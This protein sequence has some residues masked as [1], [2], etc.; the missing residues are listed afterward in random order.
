MLNPEKQVNNNRPNSLFVI[1]AKRYA[2]AGKLTEAAEICR[3]GL[4]YFPANLNG[5]VTLSQI[6]IAMNSRDRALNVLTDGYKRTGSRELFL[7]FKQIERNGKPNVVL[8][9][10]SNKSSAKLGDKETTSNSPESPQAENIAASKIDRTNLENYSQKS[11]DIKNEKI[12]PTSHVDEFV[13]DKFVEVEIIRST[14]QETDLQAKW[15][16]LKGNAAKEDL[17]SS[18]QY[19]L[20]DEVLAEGAKHELETDSIT[21]SINDSKLLEEYN[22]LN[23][24]AKQNKENRNSESNNLKLHVTESGSRLRSSNIRLIPGLEFAPL[25]Y[26]NKNEQFS[27]KDEGEVRNRKTISNLIS[28]EPTEDEN[29]I[30]DVETDST[31]EDMIVAQGVILKESYY[32]SLLNI[33][34]EEADEEYE[35]MLNSNEAERKLSPLEELA[36]RL[37]NARIPME[38]EDDTVLSPAFEPIIITETWADILANQGAYTEALKAYQTLA[39]SKPEL[40]EHF[41]NKIEDMKSKII[42]TQVQNSIVE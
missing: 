18:A 26:A 37:E 27:N 12:T 31:Q 15:N 24:I 2:N 35:K 10:N 9:N 1:E 28:N 42:E 3:R 8:I 13:V 36:K 5:Y 29:N 7:L 30:F 14:K 20:Q 4:I 21:D 41:K 33:T 22:L 6:Y 32:E 39:R 23:V 17:D 11:E 25:R 38:T 16:M 40:F 34:K 19:K